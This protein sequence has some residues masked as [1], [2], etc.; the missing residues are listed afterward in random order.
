MSDEDYQTSIEEIQSGVKEASGFVPA[1]RRE[2]G[3]VLV[4]QESLVDALLI[5]LITNGHVLVNWKLGTSRN[6]RY[7]SAGP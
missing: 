1:M 5:G 3:S 4:G 6:C 2:I 7:A